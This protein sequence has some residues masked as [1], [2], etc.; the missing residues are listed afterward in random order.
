MKRIP[1]DDDAFGPGKIREDGQMIAPVYLYQVKTAA[2]RHGPGD[3]YIQRAVTPGGPG[4]SVRSPKAVVPWCRKA[5]Q[6]R[7]STDRILTSHTGSLPRPAALTALYL[8]RGRGESVD[9]A[10]RST[11]WGAAA[12]RDV[13]RRQVE[14]GMDVGN[15]GE[16]QREAFFL[17]VRHRMSGFGGGWTRPPF[18]DVARYAGFRDWLAAQDTSKTVSNTTGVPQAIGEVRY[19]DTVMV[20]GGMRGVP[21]RPGRRR[22]FLP[23]RS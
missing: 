10:P 11:G 5:R 2:E 14:C 1:T 4:V 12:T 22:R 9:A 20:E 19:L 6:M 17:Y 21:H 13:V 23:S 3:V 8:A 15:N 18:A 16:Q 7:K